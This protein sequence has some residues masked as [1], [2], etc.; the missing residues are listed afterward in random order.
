MNAKKCDRC[1][2]YY[3]ENP[4]DLMKIGNAV[5]VIGLAWKRWDNKMQVDLCADCLSKFKN[6]FEKAE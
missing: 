5:D 6:W 4:N 1:G 3:D 2:Y